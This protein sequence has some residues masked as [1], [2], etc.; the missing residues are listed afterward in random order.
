MVGWWVRGVTQQAR[1]I[2]RS[3]PTPPT[4]PFGLSKKVE[5]Q[6]KVLTPSCAS[7]SDTS[8][9]IFEEVKLNADLEVKLL[10]QVKPVPGMLRCILCVSGSQG[11]HVGAFLASNSFLLRVIKKPLCLKLSHLPYLICDVK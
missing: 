8:N 9:A 10:A 6:S 7:L 4:Q 2:G 1:L 11:D 3:G 5:S